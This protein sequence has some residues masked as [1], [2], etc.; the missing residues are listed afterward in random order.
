MFLAD[1]SPQRALSHRKHLENHEK[2]GVGLQ[3]SRED[4][5]WEIC[6]YSLH[7]ILGRKHNF[8]STLMPEL[9]RS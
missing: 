1:T 4:G 7:S 8:T 5:I 6:C 3:G 9:F 2:E